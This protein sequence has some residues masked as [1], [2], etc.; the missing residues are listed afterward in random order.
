MFITRTAKITT[1][2]HKGLFPMEKYGWSIK[3]T[4][5]LY[6]VLILRMPGVHRY[7]PS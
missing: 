7:F 5:H 2:K 6:I 1:N 4:V 3:L